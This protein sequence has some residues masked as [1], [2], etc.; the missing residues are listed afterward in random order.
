MEAKI[1]ALLW[2]QIVA[3]VEAHP[4][5]LENVVQALFLWIEQE[6]AASVAAK[7]VPPPNP[8]A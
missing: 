6:L 2:Q 1:F 7:A 3:Y 8:A 4:Q 5:V